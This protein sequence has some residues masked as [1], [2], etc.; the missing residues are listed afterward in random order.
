[1][2]LLLPTSFAHTHTDAHILWRLRLHCG[3]GGGGEQSD[4]VWHISRVNVDIR[5]KLLN[6]SM[7]F[8]YLSHGVVF[9][10]VAKFFS[11][12]FLYEKS[13]CLIIVW[14]LFLFMW[15]N[16]VKN[17][18]FCSKKKPKCSSRTWNVHFNVPW[19]KIN[20]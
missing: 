13:K 17:S 20:L 14:V 7:C 11:A 3:G 15:K 6:K 5:I 12:F 4:G 10:D 8:S 1:M 9:L 16:Q 19:I 2:R 18:F